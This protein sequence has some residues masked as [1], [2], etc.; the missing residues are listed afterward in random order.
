[1]LSVQEYLEN[2]GLVSR[3]VPSLSAA[4]LPIVSAGFGCYAQS[5]TIRR[6]KEVPCVLM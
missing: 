5:G 3:V 4:K 2:M 1:M 6:K